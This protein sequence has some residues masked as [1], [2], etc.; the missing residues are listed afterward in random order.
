L[1]A[2][3]DGLEA[4]KRKEAWGLNQWPSQSVTDLNPFTEQSRIFTIVVELVNSRNK[5]IG[6]QEFKTGGY[7]EYNVRKCGVGMQLHLGYRCNV[8]RPSVAAYTDGHIDVRFT[9]VKAN[10]ITDNLTIRFASVN[11][12]A[13]ETAARKGILQIRTFIKGITAG[14]AI[15]DPRDGKSYRSVIIYSQTWMA[16]NL[17]YQTSNSKCPNPEGFLGLTSLFSDTDNNASKLSDKNASNCANYGRLYNWDEAKNACPAGWHLPSNAEWTELIDYVGGW[18][19]AGTKLKST[20]G[21]YAG[22]NGTDQY[23]WSAL[24]SGFGG[25][26]W[27]SATEYDA[28][29]AWHWF[30]NY[31]RDNL[32][33]DNNSKTDLFSVRC[34]AD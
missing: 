24:P 29:N 17:N 14:A 34:V 12:E 21:W 15:K 18:K 13:A 28:S 22:G 7:W 26:F 4:T 9:S 23:G 25:G 11:G 16:E 6:R 8:V 1:Q 5:V 3:Y 20:S 2:V 19:T 32:F 27:W 30:V 31:D 10:D 33:R